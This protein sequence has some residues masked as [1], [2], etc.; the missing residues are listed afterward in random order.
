MAKKAQKP[1]SGHFDLFTL[2]L[3][4]NNSKYGDEKIG[5]GPQSDEGIIPKSFIVLYSKVFWTFS[6]W[7]WWQVIG[8]KGR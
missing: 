7:S 1:S 4:W 2:V 3:D 5:R 8:K 6:V